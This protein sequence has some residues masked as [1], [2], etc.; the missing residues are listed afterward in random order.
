VSNYRIRQ[1][2]AL[3]G[4]RPERQ[5][6]VLLALATW[7]TDDTV[8]VRLGAG[9]L[10][11]TA[12]LTERNFELARIELVKAGELGYEPGGKHRGDRSVWT[13]LCLPDKGDPHEGPPKTGSPP[14]R[15]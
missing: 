7:L 6:R 4:Q 12:R 10:R 1:V 2:L 15:A 9:Q 11:A 13:L 3:R 8:T 14:A 5:M